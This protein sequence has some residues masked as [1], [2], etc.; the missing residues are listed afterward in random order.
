[1]AKV[2]TGVV[3]SDKANKTIVVSV[4]R[5][6]TH[7]LYK[8]QYTSSKR[9]QAHDEKNEAKIGDKVII[10]ETKPISATKHFMLTKIVEKA[11]IKAD[12]TVDKV[13]A[14]E[15]VV[16]TG[17][18]KAESKPKTVKPKAKTA[19]KQESGEEE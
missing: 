14:E 18:V 4:Q 5:R 8:K 6:K 15:T 11:Q 19:S 7:P 13:T 16:E 1:M 3:A 2:M 9:Y 17:K 10:S 12:E